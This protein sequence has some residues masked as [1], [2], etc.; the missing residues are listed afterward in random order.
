MSDALGMFAPEIVLVAVASAIYVAGAFVNRPD[1]WRW[2]AL[3]ALLA[4][5]VALLLVPSGRVPGLPLEADLLA[6]YVRWLG[7]GCG[8]LLVGTAWR[9]LAGPATAEFLG[10]LLLAV[11]GVMLTASAQDLLVLFV[12]LELISIPT[13]IVLYIGRH[14]ASSQ[15]A[16]AKYFYLSI[17]ASAILLY[18]FSFLYGVS[19][20]MDLAVVRQRLADL[21]GPCSAWGTLARIALGLIFGGLCFRIAA[22]PFHFYAPD[23]YQGTTHA[24]AALL[25]VLPKIAGLTALVRL[26]AVAMAELQPY[27]WPVALAVAGLTM[28]LGNVVALWQ[29]HLR[30]L[31]AYSSIAH[32]GYMLMGLAVFLVPSGREGPWDGASGLLLYLAVYAVATIGMFAVLALFGRDEQQLDH[33]DELAGLAWTSGP[34]RPMMAWLMAVFLFSLT[35]LPPLAGFWGK[36]AIFASALQVGQHAAE[37]TASWFLALAVLGVLNSAVAAA[38]YL[39]I[40][41]LMFF[42]MPRATPPVRPGT[43]GTVG[44]AVV[45]A[46]LTVVLIGLYPGLW[47]GWA[48]HSSPTVPAVVPRA[49]RPADAPEA[50]F[51]ARM[52]WVSEREP[53]GGSG[54]ALTHSSPPAN[55]QPPI[56]HACHGPSPSRSRGSG[57]PA[58]F[59][60]PAYLRAGCRSHHCVL[61]PVVSGVAGSFGG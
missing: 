23:V 7:L 34:L 30:R 53:A 45:C 36:L 6:L 20:S 56:A 9:P 11:A 51:R 25:S 31:L 61:Q 40:V 19:G 32:A 50:P 2:L 22:V 1:L 33:L 46:L 43:G 48:R 42:R 35:G 28:T 14:D 27:A 29:N 8:L 38:Y 26:V 37:P 13:Y 17:L 49:S 3:A 55:P 58:R 41:G 44:T 54:L 39:R 57:P 4:A 60:P 18:G 52:D 24:N 12:A 5:S 10:S 16:T 59:H 47:I 15:E 21:E